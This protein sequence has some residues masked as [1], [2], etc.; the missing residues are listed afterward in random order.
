MP[1]CRAVFSELFRFSLIILRSWW[2][3]LEEL[4]KVL[5]RLLEQLKAS[6]VRNNES[7]SVH[8][9]GN[10]R[11]AQIQEQVVESP[12]HWLDEHEFCVVV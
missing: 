2:G 5:M 8:I 1:S 10:A 6:M 11:D 12:G 3:R 7:S 4:S 9:C